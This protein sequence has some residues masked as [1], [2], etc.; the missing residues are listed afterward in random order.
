MQHEAVDAIVSL[1]HDGLLDPQY[2]LYVI[3]G[4]PG[5]N[6]PE[7][8]EYCRR[9]HEIVQENRAW[10]YIRII[11]HFVPV[12]DLPAWYGAADFVITGSKPTFFSVSGRS[13][14]EMAFGMP[15]ISSRA[16]LLADLNDFR[17]MKYESIEELRAH[18]LRMTKDGQLREVFSRRCTEFAENTSWTNV[19]AMHFRLYES[20]KGR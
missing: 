2:F 19:A 10:N 3:A 12:G 5:Q 4:K 17:S 6:T 7:N 16:N 11:P 8:I 13:H 9:L 14:Q 20:L 18:I 15:S 1:V